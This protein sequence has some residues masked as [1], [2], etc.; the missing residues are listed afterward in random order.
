MGPQQKAALIQGLESFLI[1]AILA[2][3]MAAAAI[4]IAHTGAIDWQEVELAFA[5]GALSAATHALVAYLKPQYPIIA[6]LL[7]QWSKDLEAR[8]LAKVPAP[9]AG[10]FTGPFVVIHTATTPQNSGVA[11]ATQANQGVDRS[12]PTS[13]V[14]LN[15][16]AKES[17]LEDTAPRAPIK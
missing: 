11:V 12:T 2:G 10:T 3:L 6:T 1:N 5:F 9:D 15:P 4:L 8:I 13:P 14:E 7:D 17:H 16:G